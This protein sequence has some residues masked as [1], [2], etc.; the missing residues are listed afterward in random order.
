MLSAPLAF[1]GTAGVARLDRSV[2]DVLA[3][4]MG[5]GLEHHYGIV[6]GDVREQLAA[7]ASLL[8]MPVVEL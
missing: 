2:D 4:V 7:L 3:T 8:S 5:E 6:Y 1:S